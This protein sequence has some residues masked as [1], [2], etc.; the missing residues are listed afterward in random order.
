MEKISSPKT[1]RAILDKYA[2]SP[3]K[4]FGQNFLVDEN[5]LNRIAGAVDCENGCVLEVGAGLGAL[6]AKLSECAKTVLSYE[7]DK[8][9]YAAL[10]ETLAGFKNVVVKNE[11]ILKADLRRDA[12]EAFNSGRFAIAANLPYYITSPCIMRFLEEGLDFSSMVLMVQKEVALR[13]TARPGDG[14]YG[15]ITAAVGFFAEPG[16]LFDV[17]RNCFYPKPDVDSA[18]IRLKRIDSDGS[19]RKEY[20]GFVKGL[21]QMRRKTVYNNLTMGMG[22]T[23]AEAEKL[24]G[25]A[26]IDA[27]VRAETLGKEDFI[28]LAKASKSTV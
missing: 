23:K 24:L 7:I 27:G 15:A 26:G 8:G 4:K 9:L 28:R 2:L 17:S 21:F 18:V 14:E 22:Y 12:A 13:L 20:L 16:I 19:I 1:A 6:T 5:I 11:D 3:L 10:Q 25:A